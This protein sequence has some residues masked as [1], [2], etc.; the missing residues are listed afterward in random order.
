LEVQ[1]KRRTL[2]GHAF[3][4]DTEWQKKLEDEFSYQE[5][6]DQLKAMEAV[7]RIWNL[8][9]RWTGCFAGMWAMANRGSAAR[10]F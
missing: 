8:R 4:A 3:G 6:V 9:Y 10:G 5:T 1:A 2:Q 7:K